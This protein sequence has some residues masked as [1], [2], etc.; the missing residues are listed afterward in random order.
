MPIS[1]HS[2]LLEAK[3]LLDK[4][5]YQEKEQ[6]IE[7]A[8]EL[9]GLALEISQKEA[10]FK[11]RWTARTMA[12]MMDDPVGKYF[13]TCLM[14][15]FFRS[16]QF[17]TQWRQFDEIKARI[18]LPTFLPSLASLGFSWVE[19]LAKPFPSLSSK[20]LETAVG[21]QTSEVITNAQPAELRKH[22]K[23]RKNEK[24]RI[25]LNH[26]G[27][28]ILGEKEA[29]NRLDIY[30][31]DLACPDVE[32]ISVKISTLY[33]Q[34]NH[35]SREKTLATLKQRLSKLYKAALENTFINHEG[36]QQAKFV[37]LDMEEFCDLDMTI[38]LFKETLSDEAFLKTRAGIVLQSYLPDS[39][40]KLLELIEFSKKRVL[41]S[42]EPIKIRLVKGANLAMEQW[43]ARQKGWPQAPYPEKKWVDANFK[44]LLHTAC[45]ACS[46]KELILGVGSHNL[47]DVCYAMALRSHLGI[48]SYLELEMLEGMAPQVR[49]A[50][51]A[52][53]GDMLLYCPAATKEEFSSAIAY[54]VRRLDE[55]T[56]QENFLRHFFHLSQQ[57]QIFSQQA[58]V[59][60]KSFDLIEQLT[61][62]SFRTPRQI[63]FCPSKE[64]EN[65]NSLNLLTRPF[66]NEPDTDWS[67]QGPASSMKQ[68]LD[69]FSQETP[70]LLPCVINAKDVYGDDFNHLGIE[71][72]ED[73]SRPGTLAFQATKAS[74]ELVNEAITCAQDQIA[75]W[76]GLSASDRAC[77]LIPLANLLRSMR[78]E[79]IG[80]MVSTCA[81]RIEEADSEVSEAIDFVEYYCR[82]AI[83]LENTS[84][85]S[86]ISRGVSLIAPPWNFP[87][88]IALGSVLGS[89][90]TGHPTLFKP[91]P[92]AYCI[93][94]K[95]AQLLWQIGIP[96]QV[97]QLLFID[98]DS[99]G[100]QLLKDPRINLI[101]LTGSSETARLFLHSSPK[102][103]LLAETGGKNTFILSDTCDR[104]LAIK[105]LIHSAFSH[106]GQKCSAVSLALVHE[107]L[108]SD[109]KFWQQLVDATS[110]LPVASAWDMQAKITPLVTHVE[111]KLL[112]AFQELE[113]GQEWILKPTQDPLNS[114]LWSPGIVRGVQSGQRRHM[115][116]FFGPILGIMPYKKL[117]EAIAL[118]NKTPYGLTAGLHTLS[119]NEENLW[120]NSIIAGNLYINR[121]TTGALV[122][123]QPFGGT[124]ASRIGQG[125]KAGGPHYLLSFYT[126]HSQ[127]CPGKNLLR[128]PEKLKYLLDLAPETLRAQLELVFKSY[129]YW[130]LHLTRI[131]DP[132]QIPGQNN[133]YY[134]IPQENYLVRW[135]GEA[136]TEKD[137]WCAL[138]AASLCQEKVW[139]SAPYW[140]STTPPAAFI[141]FHKEGEDWAIN[142][143]D[144]PL[145]TIR[146][147]GEVKEEHLS[148]F[149]EQ[150]INYILEPVCSHG[151]CEILHPLRE[152]SFCR[153]YHRYGNLGLQTF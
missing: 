30:L 123:R 117:T 82:Q 12:A 114:R 50:V 42:G 35:L 151:R 146:M 92:A 126:P 142:W 144:R 26:L 131:I 76:S 58:K 17:R 59:F 49:R 46:R 152:I 27:E 41:Q 89:L 87:L 24:I 23:Q 36:R 65:E 43:Q 11:E 40:G 95:I 28:A 88:A 45:Q 84:G 135:T 71:S 74:W 86:L 22:L 25:N 80:L 104:D 118:A 10:T 37:N 138:A 106:S 134:L 136:S 6:L 68:I 8:I 124:K 7:M 5:P 79:L 48:G 64:L 145:Q 100:L 15:R 1:N 108:Y 132:I 93:G 147:V 96:K 61:V 51:H 56:G 16:H 91:A 18:G 69:R 31:K 44:R 33:S 105:D 107:E 38:E 113:E 72:F 129:S 52:I 53:G 149:A 98:E 54:L 55:N 20:I 90:L 67:L 83:E 116:E 140:P 32:Y 3:A 119:E 63:G 115:E 29:Q 19:S 57:P 101:S 112:W 13:V 21:W 14:D 85:L 94:Y 77:R 110:S 130:Y 9:A 102:R 153:D 75:F 97:L 111:K 103:T 133:F 99:V 120:A 143:K 62:S 150:G 139:V 78:A 60:R 66:I 2:R 4:A 70:Q 127:T 109:T 39:F 81:K 137:F 122:A 128:Y 34:I 47:F 73:P 141:D 121:P 125:R 148:L